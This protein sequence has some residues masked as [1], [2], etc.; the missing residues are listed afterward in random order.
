M[1]VNYTD[2]LLDIAHHCPEFSPTQCCSCT[3]SGCGTISE[4]SCMSCS[5]WNNSNCD[6]YS[7]YIEQGFLK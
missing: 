7:K 2:R 4:I 1:I 3:S 5:N 6:I